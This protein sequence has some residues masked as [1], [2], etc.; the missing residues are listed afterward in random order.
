MKCGQLSSIEFYMHYNFNLQLIYSIK[1][2]FLV[3]A[4]TEKVLELD[5]SKYL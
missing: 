4:L 5:L 2:D 1:T 3:I